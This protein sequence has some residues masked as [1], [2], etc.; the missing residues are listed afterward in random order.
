MA[1]IRS[2]GK[3][4]GNVQPTSHDITCLEMVADIVHQVPLQGQIVLGAGSFS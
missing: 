3:E 1:L 2:H 4:K